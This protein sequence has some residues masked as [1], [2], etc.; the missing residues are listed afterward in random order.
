M[1]EMAF[2]SV[3]TITVRASR[4]STAGAIFASNST[5]SLAT[6]KNP[7]MEAHS[8]SCSVR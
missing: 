2:C 1:M 6:A 4:N 5:A 8:F 3:S 7:G